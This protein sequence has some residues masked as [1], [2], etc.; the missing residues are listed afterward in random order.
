MLEKHN[1][2]LQLYFSFFIISVCNFDTFFGAFTGF[3][4]IWSLV[5]LAIDRCIVIT[6]HIPVRYSSEKAIANFV[7]VGV[8]LLAMVGAG[9]PF[10]GYGQFVLKGTAMSCGDGDYFLKSF[11]NIFYNIMI[12]VV[13]FLIPIT[14]IISCYAVIFVKV[15]NHE[16]R[17]FDGRKGSESVDA[18]RRICRSGTLERNELKTAKAGLILVAVFCFSWAPYSIVSWIGLYGNRKSLT[19][20]AVALPAVFAKVSTI[21]NPLLYAL[22]LQSFKSKLALF[23]KKYFRLPLSSHIS[24]ER[25]QFNQTQ[26]ARSKYSDVTSHRRHSPITAV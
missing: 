3:L 20:I 19:P 12:Q 9:L 18:F 5:C 6:R 2:F 10:I 17:Y 7:V 21:L 1:T 8:W 22:L 23:C 16:R 25:S 15:R 11:P 26:G 4:S 24:W 13:Y 14:C